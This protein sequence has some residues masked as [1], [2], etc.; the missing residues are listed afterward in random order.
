VRCLAGILQNESGAG[1]KAADHKTPDAQ[2]ARAVL[3]NTH[4]GGDVENMM[5]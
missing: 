1:E 2:S 4:L 5:E 3:R